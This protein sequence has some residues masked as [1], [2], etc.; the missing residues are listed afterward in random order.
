M[1]RLLYEAIVQALAL[2]GLMDAIARL[3]GVE[4]PI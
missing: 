3:S 1:T 4:W 2:W